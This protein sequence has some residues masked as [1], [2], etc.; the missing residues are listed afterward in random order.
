VF[1]RSAPFQPAHH[2]LAIIPAH[3]APAQ[4][5]QFADPQAVVERQPY[6]R[7]V[8]L[9]AAITSCDLYQRQHFVL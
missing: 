2:Q 7:G 1:A 9:P 8:A 3:V 5:D 6:G 4:V